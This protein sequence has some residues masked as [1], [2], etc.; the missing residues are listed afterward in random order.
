MKNII[1]VNTGKLTNIYPAAKEHNRVIYAPA[2]VVQKEIEGPSVDYTHLIDVEPAWDE[3]IGFLNST[4]SRRYYSRC[5]KIG[6]T[7]G[8]WARYYEYYDKSYT[9]RLP[10]L[11]WYLCPLVLISVFVFVLYLGASL[12]FL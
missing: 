10:T 11:G 5:R 9:Y 2:S 4:Q 7:P 8:L 6:I 3:M 12:L 1:R